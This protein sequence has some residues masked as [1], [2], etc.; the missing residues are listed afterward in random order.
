MA[1]EDAMKRDVL[2]Y[3]PTDGC[4]GSRA[5][6]PGGHPHSRTPTR[7]AWRVFAWYVWYSAD[8]GFVTNVRLRALSAAAI[9][10][11]DVE[12]ESTIK[13]RQFSSALHG[14]PQNLRQIQTNA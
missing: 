1:F 14:L 10:L 7:I 6:G 12:H 4:V 13:V 3:A 2:L 8:L 11:D 9:E 5:G